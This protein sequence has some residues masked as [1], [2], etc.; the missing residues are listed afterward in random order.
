MILQTDPLFGVLPFD[1]LFIVLTVFMI[2]LVY[3]VFYVLTNPTDPYFPFK[4]HEKVDVALFQ[5][6]AS[7][8]YAYEKT[9]QGK[10]GQ[11]GLWVKGAGLYRNIDYVGGKIKYFSLYKGIDGNWH[12][13]TH[14]G[15]EVG[16]KLDSDNKFIHNRPLAEALLISD[17]NSGEKDVGLLIH[18]VP[19]IDQYRSMFESYKIEYYNR[20]KSLV[21]KLEDPKASPLAILAE[22]P[23]IAYFFLFAIVVMWFMFGYVSGVSAQM[24]GVATNTANLCKPLVINMTQDKGVTREDRKSV[25]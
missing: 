7:G 20:M 15:I 16:A 10:W 1:M 18:L 24:Q 8:H 21:V 6:N 17:K 19:S 13:N 12:P 2:P 22:V 11:N 9:I 23:H 5:L 25:V 14:I 3:Y 4:K